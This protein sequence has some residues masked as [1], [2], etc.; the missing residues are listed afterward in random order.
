MMR[1]TPF[2]YYSNI[3]YD[4]MKEDRPYDSI[5]NFTVRSGEGLW[6][7]SACLGLQF[8]LLHG[9]TGCWKPAVLETLLCEGF[10]KPEVLLS[11]QTGSVLLF[12]GSGI[13]LPSI[14]RTACWE[15]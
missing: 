4:A 6:G 9:V 3:L 2:R 14:L 12:K 13:F 5:P 10:G 7:C 8:V 15:S 11:D 1:I